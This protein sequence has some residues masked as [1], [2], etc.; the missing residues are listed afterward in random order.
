MNLENE[1][2]ELIDVNKDRT[3]WKKIKSDDGLDL[4]YVVLLPKSLADELLRVFEESVEYNGE[5]LSKVS[6]PVDFSAFY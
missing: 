1:L 4:D 3:N 6:R 2:C 5:E